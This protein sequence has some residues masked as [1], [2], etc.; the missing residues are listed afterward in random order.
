MRWS[1][2]DQDT[3]H[4]AANELK[5][6]MSQVP[7]LYALSDSLSPGKRQFEIDLTPVAEAAGLTSAMISK[8]LRASFHGLEVQRIQRG[9]DEIRVVVRYPPERRRSVRDLTGGMDKHSR[10]A[11]NSAV[12]RCNFDRA[13]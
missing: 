5:S 11:G 13:T 4:Q 3:L 2:D 8:Q 10:R 12:V 1:H 6:F 9:R 7:G